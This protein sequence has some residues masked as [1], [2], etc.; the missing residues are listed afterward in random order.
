[1]RHPHAILVSG[2]E[3]ASPRDSRKGIDM[4]KQKE[5]SRDFPQ[6][7]PE[8]HVAVFYSKILP[9]GLNG[10]VIVLISAVASEPSICQLVDY[11]SSGM[12]ER[13]DVTT[14]SHFRPALQTVEPGCRVARSESSIVGTMVRHFE[15]TGICRD[16]TGNLCPHTVSFRIAGE[17]KAHTTQSD[18]QHN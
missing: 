1:M 17:H 14:D 3:N 4:R 12:A 16:L 11:S 2:P 5:G 7:Q 13:M 6:R 10:D 15:E 9:I 18:C 8:L